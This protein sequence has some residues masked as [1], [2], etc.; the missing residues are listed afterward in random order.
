MQKGKNALCIHQKS[1]SHLLFAHVITAALKST[2][3]KME[4]GSAMPSDILHVQGGHPAYGSASKAEVTCVSSLSYI[5]L[6]SLT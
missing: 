4:G 3:A 6:I 2:P 1:S 5:T